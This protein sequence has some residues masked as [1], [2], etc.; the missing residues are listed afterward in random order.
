MYKHGWGI[1]VLSWD[2][3][4]NRGLKEWALAVGVYTPLDTFYE[5]VTFI[6]GGRKSQPLSLTH[7]QYA[8]PRPKE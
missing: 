4:C 8:H 3:A 2:S 1:E 6:E 7:R 5:S